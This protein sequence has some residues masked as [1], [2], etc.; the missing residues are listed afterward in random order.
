MWCGR[1]WKAIIVYSSACALCLCALGRCDVSLHLFSASCAAADSNRVKDFF[2]SL[3]DYLRNWSLG[4][5]ESSARQPCAQLLPVQS[6]DAPLTIQ[7]PPDKDVTK[8]GEKIDTTFSISFVTCLSEKDFSSR[9]LKWRLLF[10]PLI[11]FAQLFSRS[12]IVSHYHRG[13]KELVDSRIFSNQS[14]CVLAGNNFPLSALFFRFPFPKLKK[15][16]HLSTERKWNFVIW[17][18]R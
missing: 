7:M 12:V 6:M 15:F 9:S 10:F 8:R 13:A 18:R 1:S 17:P 14:Q 5:D 2:F 4:T 16:V 3:E 11:P